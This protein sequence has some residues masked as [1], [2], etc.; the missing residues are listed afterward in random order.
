MRFS[1][2]TVAQLFIGLAL[3][4]VCSRKVSWAP[5]DSSEQEPGD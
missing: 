5:L 3:S 1:D 2:N 4:N